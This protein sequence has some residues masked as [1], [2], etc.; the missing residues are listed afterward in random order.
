MNKLLLTAEEIK[1][2][3]SETG[4]GYKQAKSLNLISSYGAVA[5]AQLD[6]V[7]KWLDAP[8]TEHKTGTVEIGDTKMQLSRRHCSDCWQRVIVPE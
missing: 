6:K 7:L 1:R 2:L 8:C 5:Q 4:W 3:I